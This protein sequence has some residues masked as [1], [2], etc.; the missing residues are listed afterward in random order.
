MNIINYIQKKWMLLFSVIFLTFSFAQNPNWEFVASDYEYQ[1]PIASGTVEIDG[2]AYAGGTVAAFSGDEI[3]GI[4]VI[5]FN[6]VTQ[7]DVYELVVWSNST[8]G[9]AISFKFYDECNHRGE[10]I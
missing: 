2:V 10:F 4:S 7:S 6:P 9:D 1:M 5:N 8:V 3:R